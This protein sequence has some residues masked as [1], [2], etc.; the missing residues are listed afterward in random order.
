[1]GVFDIYLGDGEI[2]ADHIER[3][4]AEHGLEGEDIAAVAQV[5]DGKGVAETVGMDAGDVG[6]FSKANKQAPEGTPIQRDV[7]FRAH[8]AGGIHAGISGLA[9]GEVAPDGL[10]GAGIEVRQ[11]FFVAL[12]E[13]EELASAQV[14]V[15]NAQLAEFGGA[16]AS[17]H[18]GEDDGDIAQGGGTG[19]VAG[20]LAWPGVDAGALA[21][22]EHGAHLMFGKGLDDAL[23]RGGTFNVAHE[24]VF[25]EVL[26]DGPGEE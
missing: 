5:V 25:D 7:R 18:Q 22:G 16:Q 26:F 24:V 10:A 20:G 3:G 8:K 15:L 17:I 9:S 14:H 12:A 21:G 13:D 6:A 23:L 4:V 11:A 2:A 19:V 1:M